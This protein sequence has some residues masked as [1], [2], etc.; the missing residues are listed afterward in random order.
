[1]ATTDNIWL[2]AG[3]GK[4][5]RVKELLDSGIDVNA[6]DDFG[7]TPLQAAVSYNHYELVKFL[8][9]RG[10]DVNQRDHCGDT[11]L[12]VAEE[13]EMA[14]MLLEFGA[15]PT[16]KNSEG[17]TAAVVAFEEGWEEAAAY[18]R[19]KTGEE[20]PPQITEAYS[21]LNEEVNHDENATGEE[22]DIPNGSAFFNRVEEI[23][24]ASVGEEEKD[25]RL[26]ELVTSVVIDKLER[27][28]DKQK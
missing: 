4:L 5:D 12:Y 3:D 21:H 25:E 13:K 9:E 18:L 23:M 19:S 28:A 6:E 1:M 24:T 22:N 17:K 11:P 16:V 15:D 20:V 7:Y 14:E 26:R 2:A 27:G 8:I 10:A